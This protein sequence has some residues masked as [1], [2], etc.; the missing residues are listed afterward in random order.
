MWAICNASEHCSSKQITI[1][2][3][4]YTRL[5][6]VPYSSGRPAPDGMWSGIKCTAGRK[7]QHRG[8]TTRGQRTDRYNVP[9]S[10]ASSHHSQ[11]WNHISPLQV[12]IIM[13][14]AP[15]VW[16]LFTRGAW[17]AVAGGC[18]CTALLPPPQRLP[19]SP[20][21]TVPRCRRPP[22]PPPLAAAAPVARPPLAAAV[23]A[24]SCH[25]RRHQP[26]PLSPPPAA[27]CALSCRRR[28]P[29]PPLLLPAAAATS[30][31]YRR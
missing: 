12:G 23:A 3:P 24:P 17:M 11:C 13:P 6:G 15:A 1:K 28:R 30:T 26:P 31:C 20:T 14:A 4:Q 9:A 29:L 19:L 22:L 16:E 25:R 10:W 2:S 5:E 21:A 18:R 27:T 8:M 7:V